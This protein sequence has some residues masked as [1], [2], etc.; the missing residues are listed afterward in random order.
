M[1]HLDSHI[2]T[3]PPPARFPIKSPLDYLPSRQLKSNFLLHCFTKASTTNHR[4]HFR[5]KI[6]CTI[7]IYDGTEVEDSPHVYHR[8][9]IQRSESSSEA[10]YDPL[11]VVHDYDP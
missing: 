9:K 11:L 3:V 4:H 5:A 8:V 2:P 1:D 6:E 7:T 10:E